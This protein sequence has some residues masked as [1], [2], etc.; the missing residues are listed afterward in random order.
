MNGMGYSSLVKTACEKNENRIRDREEL[1]ERREGEGGEEEDRD[2]GNG[3]M[4][5]HNVPDEPISLWNLSLSI[6]IRMSGSINSFKIVTLSPVIILNHNNCMV[7][8][9]QT[10]NGYPSISSSSPNLRSTMTPLDYR[11]PID[12]PYLFESAPRQIP[13]G[14]LGRGDRCSSSS[15]RST[16]SRSVALELVSHLQH[17][18]FTSVTQSVEFEKWQ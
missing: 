11:I 17:E 3:K 4:H 9:K 12:L 13:D 6:P 8:V 5:V 2:G 1:W 10:Q 15:R 14:I 7:S 16:Q 18:S